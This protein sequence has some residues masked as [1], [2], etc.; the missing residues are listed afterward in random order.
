MTSNFRID[1]LSSAGS[2]NSNDVPCLSYKSNSYHG[3][4]EPPDNNNNLDDS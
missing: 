4:Y 1:S 2:E 3:S